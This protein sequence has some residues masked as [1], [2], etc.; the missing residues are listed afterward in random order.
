MSRLRVLKEHK[1]W[2]RGAGFDR[3]EITAEMDA[4]RFCPGLLES[5][6]TKLYNPRLPHTPEEHTLKMKV[7]VER[8]KEG[9]V[10]CSPRRRRN[11]VR[12]RDGCPR[13]KRGQMNPEHR[14]DR[15]RSVRD[16]MNTEYHELKVGQR[17]G[18]EFSPWSQ[19]VCAR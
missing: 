3:I 11:M 19:C 1:A 10:F 12:R 8:L 5:L 14:D 2:K 18:K 9:M 17:R 7:D 6:Y 4:Q 13:S 15:P 16:Q